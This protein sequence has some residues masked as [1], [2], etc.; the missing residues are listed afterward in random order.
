MNQAACKIQSIWRGG[1]IREFMSF[2]YNINKLKFILIEIVQVHL[3]NHFKDFIEK[4]SQI[5]KPKYVKIQIPGKGKKKITG[6]YTNKT[7]LI[8]NEKN[9]NIEKY[10][11]LLN[12]KEKDLE[13]LSKDYNDISK[14]Y[15]ELLLNNNS[16]NKKSYV[17]SISTCVDNNIISHRNNS[18]CFS[19]FP[20][21]KEFN[22]NKITE[23]ENDSF[24]ILG[25]KKLDKEENKDDKEEGI[26]LRKKRKKD[27]KSEVGEELTVLASLES[28]FFLV[29]LSAITLFD[30]R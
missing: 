24:Y 27:S 5:Q 16:E 6:I 29:S 11:S 14:K 4:L 19:I 21:K 25:N 9:K 30:C 22:E 28:N 17:P 18:S 2:F 23:M 1:Q 10:K 15:E 3:R 26:K 8:I 13:N 20:E 7:N 12:E